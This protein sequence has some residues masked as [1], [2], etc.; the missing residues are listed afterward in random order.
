M[1]YSVR[2]HQLLENLF[3]SRD[4]VWKPLKVLEYSSKKDRA[5]ATLANRVA[6]KWLATAKG[7]SSHQ[8]F[9]LCLRDY[10]YSAKLSIQLASYVPSPLFT[11]IGLKQD[12]NVIS[13]AS[14]SLPGIRQKFV[15]AA[16]LDVSNVK[17]HPATKAS[18]LCSN[19]LRTLTGYHHFKSE[20]QKT[21]VEVALAAPPGSSVAICLPTGSGKSL[22]IQAVAYQK[23]PSLTVVALPTVSLAIDQQNACRSL[24]REGQASEE[25]FEYH[26]GSNNL[27]KIKS[28]IAQNRCRL[29][30]TS[31]EAIISNKEIS[32]LLI[33]AAEKGILSNIFVD[34]AHMIDQWGKSFRLDFQYLDLFR[35]KLLGI[36]PSIRTFL[37]SATFT[38]RSIKTLEKSFGSGTNWIQVRGDALRPEIRFSFVSTHSDGE[39]KEV[40]EQLMLR[41]P[42]PLII[43]FRQPSDAKD[44]F[45]KAK[46]LG[47]QNIAVFSG[48]TDNRSRVET[49]EDWRDDNLE[50]VF[51]TSAFGVGID[52]PDI[53]TVI[54]TYIPS[55]PND[56][57]QEAG[58][59]GRDGLPSLSVIV[60]SQAKLKNG[61]DDFESAKN[62][63]SFSMRPEKM[64]ERWKAMLCSSKI[65]QG[66]YSIGIDVL[67]QYRKAKSILAYDYDLDWNAYLILLLKRWGYLEVLGADFDGPVASF[68]IKILDQRLTIT[69]GETAIATF[70]ELQIKE[71]ETSFSEVSDMKE[72][73]DGA[74]N[75]A[76]PECVGES[77]SK[78]YPW[79]MPVCSGCPAHD[80]V[81]LPSEPPSPCRVLASGG[82]A[83]ERLPSFIMELDGSDKRDCAAY[84]FRKGY[85]R[86]I[87]DDND[88]L[89]FSKEN[90]PLEGQLGF[91]EA[92]ARLALNS[93]TP[94]I[95][96]NCLPLIIDLT[97]KT[98]LS[99]SVLNLLVALKGSRV[100]FAVIADRNPRVDGYR[101]NLADFLEIEVRIAAAYL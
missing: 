14:S 13:V 70:K 17:S 47:F 11:Q 82:I 68:S 46:E 63:V 3:A 79:T 12:G 22:V 80:D 9:E 66:I 38:N 7:T 89:C 100:P 6:A 73:V 76:D 95:V 39:K 21:A 78:T 19:Y 91:D 99:G 31:P 53:R 97:S 41:L 40:I 87:S 67:P 18:L 37:L 74:L 45:Q 61:L 77:F 88:F 27:Q 50:I 65:E 52:K 35:K 33:E 58:R 10:L 94:D 4:H 96:L 23:S 101:D 64:L 8:D 90:S 72:L 43:Y 32:N 44:A 62:Y 56:Y 71:N 20:A 26:S 51:A 86:V 28:A 85:H 92:I 57:Y 98:Q 29:L 42:H 75:A 60:Y 34:E 48:K 25:I 24:I 2:E 69:S 81:R 83:P 30:F 54:H 59:G 84:L 1:D 55:S 15:D 5:L 16:F 93:G 36:S 49:M